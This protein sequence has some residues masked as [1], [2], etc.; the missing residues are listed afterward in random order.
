MDDLIEQIPCGFL[1]F[2]D[3]GKI[4]RVNARLLERLG[5]ERGDVEGKS[6]ESIMNVGSRI[7]YQTHLFPL[8]AM[9]GRVDEIFIL[10]RASD[11]SDRGFLLNGVRRDRGGRK[12]NDCA[13]MRLEERKKFEE[14]LLR[15]KK[16]AEAAQQELE[17]ANRR[18]E[19]QAVE[20]ELQQEQLEAARETAE[21]AN[22]AKSK[23]LAVM[24]HELRTPLN[25][26][27][28]YTQLIEMGVHG[29]VTDDQLKALDRISRSQKH[30][31]RLI[32]DVLNLSRIESGREEYRISEVPLGDV[33]SAVLPMVEPQ[34][35]AKGITSRT[36]IDQAYV[37]RSDKEKLEQIVLNL[38]TNATKFTPP[39]GGITLR[40]RQD[41]EKERYVC[42]DVEDTG[43][44]ISAEKQKDVFEPF[45]QVNPDQKKEGSGLG[46]AISREL[47]RGM[48][49][50]LTVTSEPGKGSV[51]TVTLP[52]V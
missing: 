46:L 16:A 37:V 43:I 30:L 38:L 51:F 40:V 33:I 45:M 17:V 13:L 52:V 2:T 3:D 22:K 12:I 42:L 34:V 15:A 48:D 29:P 32:N 5:Y 47:A 19:E 24:S 20:L 7:F 10:L 6:F 35:A 9:H 27:G 28:G 44:G 18:Y 23:F 14:A 26:I 4:E 49:A 50:D 31:L 36:L 1:S 41:V 25:A 11:G 39:G 8:L 21:K